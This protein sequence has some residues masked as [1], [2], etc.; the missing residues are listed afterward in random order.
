MQFWILTAFTAFG[1]L[2]LVLFCPET[3]YQ[4]PLILETDVA[5]PEDAGVLTEKPSRDITV[6]AT[7]GSGGA[8][9]VEHHV[10]ISNE[11]P[12]TPPRNDAISRTLFS[13]KSNYFTRTSLCLHAVSS[14]TLGFQLWWSLHSMGKYTKLISH[15]HF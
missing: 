13:G 9:D 2:V 15:Q 14:S 12:R 3:A 5:T 8:E 4:R 1:F 11:R 10:D 6:V 7:D